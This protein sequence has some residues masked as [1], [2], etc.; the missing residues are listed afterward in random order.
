[1]N[2]TPPKVVQF[3]VVLEL[4]PKLNQCK[5]NPTQT[6]LVQKVWFPLSPGGSDPPPGER[7]WEPPRKG[8]RFHLSPHRGLL[9]PGERGECSGRV[10]WLAAI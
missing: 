9:G 7:G 2:T 5:K 10:K 4:N 6:E 8:L 1:M 3:G